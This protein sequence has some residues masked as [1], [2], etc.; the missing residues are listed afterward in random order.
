MNCINGNISLITSI[1]SFVIKLDPNNKQSFHRIMHNSI[2]IKTA[3]LQLH[4]SSKPANKICKDTPIYKLCLLPFHFVKKK[5]QLVR[6]LQL[7]MIRTQMGECRP[8]PCCFSHHNHP[9]QTTPIWPTNQLTSVSGVG[10]PRNVRLRRCVAYQ[11]RQLRRKPAME[12]HNVFSSQPISMD[13]YSF[14]GPSRYHSA[15]NF[16]E[17]CRRWCENPTHTVGFRHGF[18][19]VRSLSPSRS[20]GNAISNSA[21]AA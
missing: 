17:R 2:F 16:I 9:L 5:Y 13:S 1:W 10:I 8:K 7:G 12:D 14:T 11:R 18:L 4:R 20:L 6:L 19:P 21:R 15:P 3:K